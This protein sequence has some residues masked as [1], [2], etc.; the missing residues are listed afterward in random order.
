VSVTGIVEMTLEARDLD[1]LE[2]PEGN[3]VEVWDFFERGEGE[4][5]GVDAVS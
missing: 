3:A 4:R 5:Q 1:G 2:D